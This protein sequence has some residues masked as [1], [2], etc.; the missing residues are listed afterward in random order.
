M[1]RTRGGW[2]EQ[3]EEEGELGEG[4]EDKERVGRTKGRIDRTRGG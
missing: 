1:E 4:G 3:W 2:D